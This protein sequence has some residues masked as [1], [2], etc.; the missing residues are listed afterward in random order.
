MQEV[1]VREYLVDMNATQAAIR[2]GYS[3]ATAMEQGYQLLQ[4][5]SVR[6]AVQARLKERFD[7]ID[8]TAERVLLEMFRVATV[9]LAQAYDE[10]G[11]LLCLT[12]MPEDI[13]RAISAFESEQENVGTSQEPEY[14]TVRKIKT[15]DKTK[16]LEM[17]GKYF[18]LLTERVE[19]SDG[20]A[21]RL[22]RARKR[23]EKA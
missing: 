16:A 14:V 13:R 19:I 17:L 20:I 18:K 9:D 8:L 11:R 7:R 3:V 21:D 22:A 6:A 10:Q 1:F 5:P 4:K 12:Q 15:Y 23:K 2:A